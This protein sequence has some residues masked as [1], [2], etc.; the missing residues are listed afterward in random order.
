MGYQ[1]LFW[2][3]IELQS[4]FCIK[5]KTLVFIVV[6]GIKW[7]SYVTSCTY[8]T[9]TENYTNIIS[10]M[11]DKFVFGKYTKQLASNSVNCDTLALIVTSSSKKCGIL[12]L[13]VWWVPF[14]INSQQE[15]SLPITILVNIQNAINIKSGVHCQIFSDFN[16]NIKL[17]P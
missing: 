8:T 13:H 15:F 2:G 1:V 12:K 10:C 16:G 4:S 9:S 3:V 6:L 7:D 5:T 11:G 14:L 17:S